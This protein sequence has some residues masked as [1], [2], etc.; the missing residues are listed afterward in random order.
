MPQ[1]AWEFR[2]IVEV[3]YTPQKAA[4]RP[5]FREGSLSIVSGRATL[6]DAVQREVDTETVTE[7]LLQQLRLGSEIE[8]PGHVVSHNRRAQTYV[9]HSASQS[10]R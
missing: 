10:R 1:A 8:F 6:L 5:K 4:R 2:G 3:L 9:C 7:A